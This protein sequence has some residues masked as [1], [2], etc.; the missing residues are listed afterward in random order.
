VLIIAADD[1]YSIYVN[2]INGENCSY[3]LYGFV[4]SEVYH[5]LVFMESAVL[6]CDFNKVIATKY[7]SVFTYTL[8]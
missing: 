1:E 8:E 3:I 5:R 2:K 4:Y 6:I 7:L